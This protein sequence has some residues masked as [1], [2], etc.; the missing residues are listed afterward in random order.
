MT[1]KPLFKI[2]DR[3]LIADRELTGKVVM[4]DANVMTMGWLY[5]VQKE[6]WNFLGYQITIGGTRILCN[7][8]ELVGV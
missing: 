7:E 3:V 6:G 4:I 2:G 1:R 5:T 8:N